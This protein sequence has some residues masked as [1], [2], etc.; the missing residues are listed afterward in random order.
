MKTLM[1]I[2]C[3]MASRSNAE[4]QWPEINVSDATISYIGGYCMASLYDLYQIS[5][6]KERDIHK[7]RRGYEIA[8]YAIPWPLGEEVPYVWWKLGLGAA[9]GLAMELRA[10][11]RENRQFGWGNI[12]W[13]AL[14]GL[15]CMVIH[16]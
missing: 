8:A 13:G 7:T 12:G 10:A 1:L 11:D 6:G 14:G 9:T 4:I 16:F 5:S 15:T 3:L 2:L